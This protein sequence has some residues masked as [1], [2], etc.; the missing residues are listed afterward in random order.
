MQSS[1][2]LGNTFSRAWQLLSN[3]WIIIVPAIVIAVICGI[4]IALLGMFGFASA[5]GFGA[6]GMG[7]A[8]MG[9]MM[10]TGML[11]A[12]ILLLASILT[13]A[14]TTGMAQAAWRTG[15]ATLD[16]GAAAFRQDAGSL[17]AAVVLLLII[18]LIAMILVPFTLGLSA[19]AFWLFFI[20]TFAS[21][22]VGKRSGTDALAESARI[23]SKNFLMTLLV[24]IL[25]AVAFAIA[26][27]VGSVLHHIPL[28]GTIVSYVIN[29][30][31]AAF[32]T[33]VIVGEYIKLRPSIETVGVGTPP[34]ASPPA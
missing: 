12:L 9:A 17:V 13:V 19:L 26:A 10:L 7:G 24:V 8:G 22:V 16:D 3:N 6:V 34:S 1:E 25:L 27:W 14:Y 15:K 32:A 23:T 4:V 31:V 21:V 29:Q 11:L 20:Y 28:L 30:A 33:L 18:G 5:V 2:D